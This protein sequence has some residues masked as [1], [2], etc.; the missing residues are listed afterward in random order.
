VQTAPL[1][2]RNGSERRKRSLI[3]YW[4]G[5]L[6]PRRRAG[7]RTR[8]QIYPLVD[9]HPARVFALV[10]ATLCLCAAD[11]VLTVV[12]MANG[13]IEVNPV[14]ALFVPHELGWFAAVK[15]T[16]T[17]AGMLVLVVGSRM[18]LFRKFSGE[19]LLYLILAC[20]LALV[21]YEMRLLDAIF[22]G[23]G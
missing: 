3:A 20:Y 16:L 7:R 6:T 2:R 21:T 9:W 8:D 22:S 4:R 12:L 13:A 10:F 15:L 18:R 1:E 23:A 5:A 17:A 19:I 11:G 14:M